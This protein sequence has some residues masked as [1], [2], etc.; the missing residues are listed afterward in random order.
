MKVFILAEYDNIRFGRRLLEDVED[1]MISSQPALNNPSLNV[2]SAIKKKIAHADVVLV[3]IDEKF[4]DSL[5]F[6]SEMK[7]ALISARENKQQILIPVLINGANLPTFLYGQKYINCDVESEEDLIKA[8]K[9]IE[10]TLYYRKKYSHKTN[11]RTH[12]RSVT[13]IILT[14]ATEAFAMFYIIVL[15]K[16]GE[17]NSYNKMFEFDYIT[18]VEG[19]IALL[20]T[21][22][23]FI[24]FLLLIK[25]KHREDDEET[26]ESYSQRV[27]TA[28]VPKVVN[29]EQRT[30]LD[31]E[32]KTPDVDALGLMMLN[33]ED[34]NE[35][36]IWSQKQAKASFVFAVITCIVGL[37][38]IVVATVLYM[39]AKSNFQGSLIL[40]IGGAITELI[41]GTAL[42]VYKN[43]LVQL[44]HYHKAMHEDE[45]F[46]SSVNLLGKFSTVE[47]QDDMLREIIRSEI[48]MNMICID[49]GTE[50]IT[51]SK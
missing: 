22:I 48:Q 30:T 45:R 29:N 24:N 7:L 11:E 38:L 40:A 20:A 32:E 31:S 36:Y 41:A 43:S 5:L 25:R 3:V 50:I 8:K 6:D 2:G 1:A 51:N 33:L 23:V 16:F 15:L 19:I 49:N 39:I 27:K 35:F 42:V 47:A 28:I 4:H 37:A 46:L 12:S 21:L 14:V 26:R 44:N 18:A 34:I 10:R 9:A 17:F 13:M